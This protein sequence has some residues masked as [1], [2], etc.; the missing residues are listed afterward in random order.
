VSLATLLEANVVVDAHTCEHRQL[1]PAQ[2]RHA[3]APVALDPDVLRLDQLAPGA[4]E[5]SDAVVG[6]HDLTVPG[7]SPG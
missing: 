1:L 5:L 7:P 6:L 2:P 4:Q 3:P